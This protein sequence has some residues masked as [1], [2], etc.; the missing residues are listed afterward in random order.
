MTQ[1]RGKSKTLL[2]APVPLDV[3]ILVEKIRDNDEEALKCLL[4]ERIPGSDVELLW[5]ERSSTDVSSSREGITAAPVTNTVP[6]SSQPPPTAL[7]VTALCSVQP[8]LDLDRQFNTLGRPASHG[9]ADCSAIVHAY[10][11]WRETSLVFVTETHMLCSFLARASA[12]A[13]VE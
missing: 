5:S 4:R 12:I 10:L 2:F 8:S 11:Q 1:A 7:L 9:S 13:T 3:P 6:S